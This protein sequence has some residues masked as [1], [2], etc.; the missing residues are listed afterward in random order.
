MMRLRLIFLLIGTASAAWASDSEQKP[1]PRPRLSEAT[2]SEG[3]H[4][5]PQAH[6]SNPG[7][8]SSAVAQETTQYPVI[9]ADHG[10]VGRINGPSPLSHPFDLRDGGTFEK[11]DGKLL[12]AETMLQYDAPNAGWDF[13]RISW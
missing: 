9:G 5:L 6:V 8:A 13:F 1:A 4:L 2:L 3:M 10:M 11:F 7:V 12:S